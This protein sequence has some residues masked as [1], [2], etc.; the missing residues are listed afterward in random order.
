MAQWI[1][2]EHDY[3]NT[4]VRIAVSKHEGQVDKQGMPYI[5]HPMAVA[6]MVSTPVQKCAALLH[7]ILEDTD[8]TE[9]RLLKAGIPQR[10]VE[11]VKLVSH[12]KPCEGQEYDAYLARVKADPDARAVK[13]ADLEH[14]TDP[15]RVATDE[16]AEERAA[17]Y[18]RAKAFLSAED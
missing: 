18:E 6:S 1:K 10:V 13:L 4:A 7:D 17:K 3:I 11:I 12:E 5:L 2:T 15:E 8:M 9:E 14:N 16:H